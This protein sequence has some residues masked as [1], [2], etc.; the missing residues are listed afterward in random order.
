M[1]MQM[2]G[3]NGIFSVPSEHLPGLIALIVFPLA[4]WCVIAVI[5]AGANRGYRRTAALN[6]RLDSLSFTARVTLVAMLVGAVV[7]AAIIP[8]HWSDS[9]VLA[10]LFVADV[11]GFLAASVW[12]VLQRPHWRLAAFGMLA[13]TVA[14]YVFY[15]LKGW[16]TPDPVGLITTG[17]ELTAGLVL[18]MP[19]AARSGAPIGR[20]WTLLASMPIAA[21]TMVGA[22]MLSG[23][24]TTGG[25]QAG[26]AVSHTGM[27]SM[28]SRGEATPS[29]TRS[30]PS[31]TGDPTTQQAT[32]MPAMSGTSGASGSDSMPTMSNTPPSSSTGSMPGMGGS[33]SSGQGSGSMPGMGGGG[34]GNSGTG[35]LSLA[36]TSP[37]G[38][39]TW[40]LSMGSMGAG[41][42]MVTPNCTASPT[43][44]QQGSAVALVDQTVAAV[45]RYQSLANARA[46]GYVPI[47][48]TGLAVVHYAKPALINDGNILDPNAIESLVY[49]NTPHGAILVA[50]MYLMASNQVGATPPMPGGC[51]T[52]WHIHTNLC[53]SDSNGTVVGVTSGG[54]CKA[55]SSNHVSQPMLHVWLAPIPGGPLVVDATDAQVVQAAE[56]LPTPSPANPTA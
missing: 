11:V 54:A 16:E 53:F 52:E 20:R 17:V 3:S 4:A 36:T 21:I 38:P 8:T 56:Q 22:A 2:T 13:G 33:A 49:A 10:L 50:A 51:L 35:D 7:H 32:S 48:P 5:R 31:M 43:A 12:L 30:M 28:S 19:A 40:P 42:Q 23:A 14:G 29:S 41:M 1:G 37:A 15:A 46:D 9:R 6:A 25:L 24:S 39:I 44:A 27:P 18:L 47:T 26:A 45:A 34:S 55:G